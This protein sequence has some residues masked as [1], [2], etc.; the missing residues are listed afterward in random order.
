MAKAKKC[1]HGRD[2]RFKR[3][4][5]CRKAPKA[6]AKRRTSARGPAVSAY[7]PHWT[8]FKQR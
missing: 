3:K 1:R 6:K 2:Q 7:Q 4:V 5:V 8:T